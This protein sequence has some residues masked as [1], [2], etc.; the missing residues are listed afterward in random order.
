MPSKRGVIAFCRYFELIWSKQIDSS[1][2][3]RSPKTLFQQAFLSSPPHS[4]G[5]AN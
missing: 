3:C 4:G 1:S 2:C 5:S